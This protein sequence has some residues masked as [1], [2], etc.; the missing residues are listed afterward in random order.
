MLNRKKII[1]AF[2]WLMFQSD[3]QLVISYD[4]LWSIFE[5]NF[6]LINPHDG[7]KETLAVYAILANGKWD[8]KNRL[9]TW[10]GVDLVYNVINNNR[11]MRRHLKWVC[12][13]RA[14]WV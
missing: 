1:K 3:Y 9:F 13:H 14:E 10:P 12:D 2:N 6:D 4:Q 8:N 5:D 7:Y 11:A